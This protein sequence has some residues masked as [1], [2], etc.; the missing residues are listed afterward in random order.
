M[1]YGGGVKIVQNQQV[2]WLAL[3]YVNMGPNNII[4]CPVFGDNSGG[5]AFGSK[6]LRGMS[7]PFVV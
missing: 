3:E 6:Y 1:F 5:Q 7:H 2:S 4:C